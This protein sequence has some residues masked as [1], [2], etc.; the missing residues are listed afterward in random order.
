MAGERGTNYVCV[1][2]GGGYEKGKKTAG[3]I[4]RDFCMI[5]KPME[6]SLGRPSGD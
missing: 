1:C 2:G 6:L 4:K 5:F 3:K